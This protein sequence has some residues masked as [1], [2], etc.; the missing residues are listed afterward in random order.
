M[1]QKT[2]AKMKMELTEDYVWGRT[3]IFDEDHQVVQ[4]RLPLW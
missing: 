2:T 4:M 1:K 3:S